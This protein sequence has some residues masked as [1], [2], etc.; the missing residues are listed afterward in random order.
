[1]LCKRESSVHLNAEVSQRSLY[2]NRVSVDDEFGV[3]KFVFLRKNDCLGL[4]R[5]E[6]KPVLTHPGRYRVEGR[7]HEGR[8]FLAHPCDPQDA[9]VVGEG[10]ELDA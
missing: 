6:F 2:G 7:V 5:S 9:D 10:N 3:R 8:G 4:L 1:M